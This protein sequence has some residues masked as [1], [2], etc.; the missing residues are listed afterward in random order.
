MRWEAVRW[1]DHLM[2]EKGVHSEVAGA[3]A[4]QHASAV[5]RGGL[6]FHF[7]LVSKRGLRRDVS[8]NQGSI[9]NSEQVR[10]KYLQ[11]CE[12]C[13]LASAARP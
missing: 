3:G 6:A 1:E 11:K 10:S 12:V 13:V 9:S 4:A 5:G 7:M 2:N 8:P